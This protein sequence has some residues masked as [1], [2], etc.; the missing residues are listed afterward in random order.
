MN[1]KG[2]ARLKLVMLFLLIGSFLFV[3]AGEEPKQIEKEKTA[4][5]EKCT[6]CNNPTETSIML[7]AED[8][9]SRVIVKE[10]GKC[11]FVDA[12]AENDKDYE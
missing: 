7:E 11:G 12:W 10:C 8:G 4:H 3:G 5:V 1:K 9:D 2:K 6:H